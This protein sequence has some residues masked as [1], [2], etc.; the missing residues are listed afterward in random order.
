MMPSSSPR[1]RTIGTPAALLQALAKVQGL[2]GRL[3]AWVCLMC[4]GLRQELCV[5]SSTEVGAQKSGCQCRRAG[6]PCKSP[7]CARATPNKMGARHF[8]LRHLPRAMLYGQ[9]T[10]AAAAALSWFDACNQGWPPAAVALALLAQP[11]QAPLSDLAPCLGCG[12]LVLWPACTWDHSS[13]ALCFGCR[14]R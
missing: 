14:A 10:A 12:A 3:T 2:P 7:A 11:L 1:M 5:K 8:G 9:A 4:T 13:C 6:R